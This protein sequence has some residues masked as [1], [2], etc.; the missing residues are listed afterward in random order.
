[1]NVNDEVVAALA[2]LSVRRL[3]HFTPSRNL[4]HILRTREIRTTAALES[5]P[6]ESAFT[7]T[8]TERFDG[9]KDKI[10]CSLLY[11]NTYYLHKAREKEPARN[12]PDWSI[13]LLDPQLAAREGTLFCP[14]NAAAGRGGSLAAGPEGLR[15]CYAPAI[16]G[17]GA[18]WRRGDRH[19]P[20]AP[21][22]LQAEVLIPGAIPLTSV[23]AIVL[24]S[25]AHVRQERAR[26]RQVGLDPNTVQ[27]RV[28]SGMFDK[29]TVANAARYSATLVEANWTEE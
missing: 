29:T 21:T 2:D 18:T 12:Y 23:E 24:P 26:L 27:W 7:T 10:C 3:V 25:E 9:H 5:D 11:P 19:R 6:P 8:D 16:N 15:A 17:S 13:L 28:S 22:D 20:G 1:M 14:R 4:P